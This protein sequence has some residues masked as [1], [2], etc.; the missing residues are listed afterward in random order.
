MADEIDY[1][2]AFLTGFLGG[3]HCVGMC[4]A[5]VSAF[6]LRLGPFGRQTIVIAGYHGARVAVYALVGVLAAALGLTLVSTGIIGKAQAL[7]QVFAG[8]LVIILGFDLMGLLPFRLP[9][10]GLPAAAIERLLVGQGRRGPVQAAAVGGLINGLMPCALTLAMA[11]KATTAAN[12]LQGGLLMLSFGLGT[13]PAMLLVGLASQ[14]IG[15][16]PRRWILKVAGLA[17]VAMGFATALQGV[18]FFEVMRN[19]PNW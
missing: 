2:L 17:V 6:F 10:I 12:P 15:K 14:R 8:T 9:V 13:V 5:L 7:L 11:V 1:G 19:L 3:G 16:A 18:R 4:G